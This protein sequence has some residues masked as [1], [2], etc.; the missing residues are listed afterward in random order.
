MSGNR[1]PSFI[2]ITEDG[3]RKSV[4]VFHCVFPCIP[5]EHEIKSEPIFSPI[6]QGRDRQENSAE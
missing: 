3:A 1:S 2:H 6:S 5:L 4:T